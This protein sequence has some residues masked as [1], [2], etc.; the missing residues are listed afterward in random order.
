MQLSKIETITG[1]R[2]SIR[3]I[4][5]EAPPLDREAL[6]ILR[7]NIV[8]FDPPPAVESRKPVVVTVH[9]PV[10]RSMFDFSLFRMRRTV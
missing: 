1:V 3:R 7:D 8:V 5:G 9:R 4:V 2:D 6:K 10:W